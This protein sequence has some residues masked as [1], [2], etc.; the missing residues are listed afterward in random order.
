MTRKKKN[1]AVR[2]IQIGVCI[3]IFD[4]L[5][6]NGESCLQKTLQERRDCLFTNVK[7]ITGK[8]QYVKYENTQDVDQI[9]D[10]LNESCKIGCEGLML[11]TLHDNST[12]EPS[13][14]TFKW[15]K[16]KRDYL[17]SSLGDSL[18]LVPIGAKFGEG[19]RVGLYGSFLLAAYNDES[20]VYETTTMIGTGFSDEALKEIHATLKQHIIQEPLEE[21][22]ILNIN[23]S[24]NKPDVWFSPVMVME[25]KATDFLLSNL[26]SCSRNE[27]TDH[28][29]ISLR[30]PRLIKIRE[31]KEP[32]DATPSSMIHD[33]YSQQAS[34]LNQNNTKFDDDDMY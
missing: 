10:L 3:Y 27:T 11:K 17:D 1:V 13:S 6:F 24:K 28:R 30:F 14:R 32:R 22:D 16:M 23:H 34:I 26:Y 2:D 7:E 21:Y 25:I 9:Q 8:V 31:D 33:M 4:L 15:L 5:L 20:E 18:D 29:G 12:Y 19:K